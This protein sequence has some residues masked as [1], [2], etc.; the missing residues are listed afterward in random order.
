MVNIVLFQLE[1]TYWK[2]VCSINKTPKEVFAAFNPSSSAPF[3]FQHQT[4]GNIYVYIDTM[5]LGMQIAK[6]V[7]ALQIGFTKHH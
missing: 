1:K 7:S 4:D 3:S 2:D 6:K 5:L